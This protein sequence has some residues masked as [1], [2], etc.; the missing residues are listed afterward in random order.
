MGHGLRRDGYIQQA[1]DSGQQAVS[2]SVISYLLFGKPAA[3]SCLEGLNDL[4]DF[5]A[6]Y[7]FNGFN[8]FNDLNGLSKKSGLEFDL[9]VLS[10]LFSFRHFGPSC[11]GLAS[12]Q[13]ANS[14]QPS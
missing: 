2:L 8:D 9:V 13:C 6:F 11:L 14:V 10:T 3:M 7:D 1:A 5:Y 12:C 4:Y